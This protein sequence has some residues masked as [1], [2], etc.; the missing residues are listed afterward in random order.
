MSAKDQK[1]VKEVHSIIDVLHNE[2][3]RIMK[4]G[5]QACIGIWI[6]IF[7]FCCLPKLLFP[8]YKMISFINPDVLIFTFMSLGGS[9]T[10]LVCN[11]IMNHIYS[12]KYPYIEQYRIQKKP[13]P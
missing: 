8:L 4:K 12:S 10:H 9:M 1:Y 3:V 7:F 11:L 5:I 6:S 13:W 2:K